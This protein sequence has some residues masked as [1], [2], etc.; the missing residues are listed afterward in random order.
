MRKFSVVGRFLWMAALCAPAAALAQVA[1]TV[2]GVNMR[3]G[4]DSSYPQV[5]WLP[6]GTTINVVGCV[7]GWRWC[8]V[9]AG[10]TRGWVYSKYISYTYQ[11]QP[12]VVYNGGPTLGIPL[13]SFSIGPYWDNYYRGRPWYGN[14]N[15]WYHRP[16]APPPVWRPPAHYHPVSPPPHYNNPPHYNP[17]PQHAQPR[18]P[19]YTP[20][21]NSGRPP[22]TG[23]PPNSGHPPSGRPGS[24]P[25]GTDRPN[26]PN[27][28]AHPN[29]QQ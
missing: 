24:Y 23:Q 12:I 13:I 3:A 29:A 10:P 18:P 8:D 1:V 5:S 28:Q 4:P 16:V 9:I 6:G 14:R 21:P 26:R 17:P 22:N 20:P 15:Y 11:N 19:H 27:D 25:G 7:E 2:Q